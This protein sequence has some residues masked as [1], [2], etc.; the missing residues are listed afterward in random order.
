MTHHPRNPPIFPKM[1]PKA[2]PLLER[3]FLRCCEH[4][5]LLG[6][7]F[8]LIDTHSAAG[9][10]SNSPSHRPSLICVSPVFLLLSLQIFLRIFL[11]FRER[12]PSCPSSGAP[13]LDLETW[14]PVM[15]TPQGTPQGSV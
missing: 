14:E 12:R 6:L 4:P 3:R 10:S 15:A 2:T 1:P 5:H 13:L 11:G 8:I 9:R 7:M